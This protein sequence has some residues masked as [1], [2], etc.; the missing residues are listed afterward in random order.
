ME[1]SEMQHLEGENRRSKQ[2]VAEQTLDIQA[3][4]AVVATK[5][6]SAIARREAVGWLLTTG[7]SLRR[8]VASPGSAWRRGGIS[9]EMQAT[10]RSC[11]GGRP[12]RGGA[13]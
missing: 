5:L 8:A 2:F 9:A 11:R 4:R 13:G 10:Q 6:M 7:A 12:I 1:L 3:L